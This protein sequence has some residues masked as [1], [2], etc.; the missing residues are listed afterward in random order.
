MPTGEMPDDSIHRNLKSPDG[1]DE[2]ASD[3][4][5]AVL[6]KDADDADAKYIKTKSDA[7]KK[8]AINKQLIAANYLM[9]EANLSPK[10]KYRPAL[11]RYN[12]ILEL[13]PTNE[14]AKQNKQ[15]IEEIYQQMGVPVPTS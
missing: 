10:K 14:E 4:K 12:R 8:E 3:E 6:T 7:D 1:H 9:F 2:E 13:D 15:Q 5:V 11:K